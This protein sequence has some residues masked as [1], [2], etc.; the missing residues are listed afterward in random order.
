MGLYGFLNSIVFTLFGI[1][2]VLVK[3]ILMVAPIVF[4]FILC[5]NELI[6]RWWIV[7]NILYFDDTLKMIVYTLMNL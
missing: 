1:F 4:A 5:F 3:L 2:F 7:K 6:N